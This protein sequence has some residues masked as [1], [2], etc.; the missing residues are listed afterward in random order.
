MTFE[1]IRRQLPQRAYTRRFNTPLR[2]PLSEAID[3]MDV[4]QT[5]C[6]FFPKPEGVAIQTWRAKIS[7]YC[8]RLH[9]RAEDVRKYKTRTITQ[10]GAIGVGVWRLT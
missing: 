6:V 5:A 3:R 8:V 4:S 2:S 9:Y 7:G 10:D 1:K